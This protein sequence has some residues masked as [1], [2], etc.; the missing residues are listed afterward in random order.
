MS[1]AIGYLHFLKTK[2][3]NVLEK[4]YLF[5]LK[6]L[7]KEEW[8]TSEENILV[9]SASKCIKVSSLIFPFVAKKAS[10]I[11]IEM[12]KK[13]FNCLDKKSFFFAC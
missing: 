10:G 4:S 3:R 5:L 13:I 1:N 12:T 2:T 8:Q 7:A 6:Q 11:H 9:W